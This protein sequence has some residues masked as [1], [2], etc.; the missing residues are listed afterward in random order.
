[1][2]AK[3]AYTDRADL[4]RFTGS[5]LCNYC[6]PYWYKCDDGR[7]RQRIPKEQNVL[8]KFATL[9]NDRK[10][11]I[12]GPDANNVESV[13][14]DITLKAPDTAKVPVTVAPIPAPTVPNHI[15]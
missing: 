15:R 9:R 14:M 8:Y 13:N 12:E 2:E 10:Y 6:K 4:F 7:S 5:N 11:T 3:N 1:M